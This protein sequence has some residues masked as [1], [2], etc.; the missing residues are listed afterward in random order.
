MLAFYSG[1][2]L[3]AIPTSAVELLTWILNSFALAV[4]GTNAYEE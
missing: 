4:L 2:T 1:A 3:G